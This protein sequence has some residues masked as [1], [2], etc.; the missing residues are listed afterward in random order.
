M[1]YVLNETPLRTTNGFKINDLE[2]ELDVPTVNNF[3]EYKF[4]ENINAKQEVKD[5]FKEV[6]DISSSTIILD[7]VK[8]I[9]KGKDEKES[10]EEV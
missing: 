8:K 2:I 6:K 7:E 4:S 10:K 1:K 9:I 5:N 3:G